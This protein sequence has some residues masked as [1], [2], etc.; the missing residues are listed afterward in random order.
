VTTKFDV[1]GVTVILRRNTAN[2]VIAANLY[3]LGGARQITPANA[4]IEALLLLAASAARAGSRRDGAAAHRTLGST[5]SIEANDDWSAIGLHAIRGTFDS[6]WA[7]LAGPRDGSDAFALATWRSRAI[8]SSREHVSVR[9]IRTA[10]PKS[11]RTA[12]CTC[13]IPYALEAT[14]NAGVARGD[15]GA[16]TPRR[17]TH[18]SS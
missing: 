8:S 6:T 15:H 11:S 10:Q 12:C 7:I 16:T 3:L 2:E 1:D 17:T 14:G 9:R 5:I 18:N 4:G 13:S